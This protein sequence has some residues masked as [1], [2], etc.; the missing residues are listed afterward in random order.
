MQQQIE[1]LKTH[2]NRRF[3]NEEN[4]TVVVRVDDMHVAMKKL[5]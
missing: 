4:K 2:H 1:T 5:R 3:L